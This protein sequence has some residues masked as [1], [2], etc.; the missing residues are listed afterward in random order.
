M[1]NHW[2]QINPELIGAADIRSMRRHT[3]ASYRVYGRGND[4]IAASGFFSLFPELAQFSPTTILLGF[5]SVIVS[6]GIMS[7][8]VISNGVPLP[9]IVERAFQPAFQINTGYSSERDA[10]LAKLEKNRLRTLAGKVH[11]VSDLI[12]NR[13]R[14]LSSSSKELAYAIVIESERAGYDPLF[15]AAVINSESTFRKN[16]RSPVGA[17]GLMQLLPA[18]GKYIASKKRLAWKGT[19]SLS[20]PHTNIRL[21]IA[22]LQYLERKFK[23][24]RKQMLIAYNWGPGSLSKSLKRGGTPPSSTIKYAN[25]IMSNHT[26]WRSQYKGKQH[27]YRFLNSNYVHS[28]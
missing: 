4:T 21:G 23:G 8:I 2:L 17:R 27:Q 6:L 11:F 18:T 12:K 25:T 14:R 20:E 5:A 10:F 7:F 9:D 16:A 24:N 19:G 1:K 15:V 3:R 13:N 28:S 26:R 22:Y